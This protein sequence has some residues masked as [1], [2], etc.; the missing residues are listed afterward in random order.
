MSVIPFARRSPQEETAEDPRL[1]EK[2]GTFVKAE[3]TPYQSVVEGS[4]DRQRDLF[5]H[6][7]PRLVDLTDRE[8]IQELKYWKRKVG[9]RFPYPE[10]SRP[11]IFIDEMLQPGMRVHNHSTRAALR[12]ACVALRGVLVPR[13]R[14]KARI[15]FCLD[16]DDPRPVG[17]CQETD[18]I[19]LLRLVH[20]RHLRDFSEE[21]CKFV[22]L[23][24][25]RLRRKGLG[26]FVF[27]TR[28]RVY[29]E[30][31]LV[32]SDWRLVQVLASLVGSCRFNEG[33][34][35]FTADIW[36]RASREGRQGFQF[37]GE[38]ERNKAR[39]LY[40]LVAFRDVVL[41]PQDIEKFKRQVGLS[42]VSIWDP[43]PR[44]PGLYRTTKEVEPQLPAGQ[45]DLLARL[46]QP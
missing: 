6:Y 27:K 26:K 10:G 42:Q 3:L 25:R 22:K 29:A 18:A 19:L 7:M 41:H 44:Q 43:S 1:P 17:F 35:S 34:L 36:S 23:N 20:L 31:L 32:G 30:L 11:A 15:A 21:E 9:S 46:E 13:F 40:G 5:E 38:W 39:R 4:K 33:E 2:A 8:L 45:L 37:K 24:L 28:D 16:A 12:R 14:V